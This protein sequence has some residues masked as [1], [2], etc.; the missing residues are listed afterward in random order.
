MRKNANDKCYYR[1]SCFNTVFIQ[2]EM[3]NHGIEFDLFYEEES[4]QTSGQRGNERMYRFCHQEYNQ[5]PNWALISDVMTLT[6]I[7]E[8]ALV[9]NEPTV[10][11][12]VF[13]FCHTVSGRMLSIN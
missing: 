9:E 8:I 6:A 3:E 12:T 4:V 11:P 2:D 5:R 10:E 7:C 1:Y 13:T